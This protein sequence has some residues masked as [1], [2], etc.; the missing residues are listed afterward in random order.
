MWESVEAKKGHN[1]ARRPETDD[2]SVISIPHRH[3]D[4]AALERKPI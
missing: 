3:R 2:K 4:G 1:V